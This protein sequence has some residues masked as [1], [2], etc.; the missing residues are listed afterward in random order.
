[1]I[2]TTEY[3]LGTIGLGVETLN[4]TDSSQLTFL[5]TLAN[6]QSVIPSLSY[7]YTAGAYYRE[8][9]HPSNL[10][11]LRLLFDNIF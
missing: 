11:S 4:F 5:S 8:S 1:M 7:G 2:N 9:C 6:N 10:G 3:W